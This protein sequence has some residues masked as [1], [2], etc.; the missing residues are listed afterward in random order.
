MDFTSF[1][2]P[3]FPLILGSMTAFAEVPV[4]LHTSPGQNVSPDRLNAILYAKQCPTLEQLKPS[5]VCDAFQDVYT[6]VDQVT[7]YLDQSVNNK[8]E[9]IVFGQESERRP[10]W[11]Y[12]ASME[13]KQLADE[14]AIIHALLPPAT[15]SKSA[16]KGSGKNEMTWYGTFFN[17]SFNDAA[18][19]A[20]ITSEWIQSSYFSKIDGMSAIA[21]VHQGLDEFAKS[22]NS[23]FNEKLAQT[24]KLNDWK[25]SLFKRWQTQC[26]DHD[27]SI[28]T[29]S[30]MKQEIE[31][32]N[33]VISIGYSGEVD[34]ADQR[35]RTRECLFNQK[36][37][38][39]TLQKATENSSPNCKTE[40][41][42]KQ[43]LFDSAF[44]ALVPLMKHLP[45]IW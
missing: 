33:R 8:D 2:N 3:I 23:P 10:S 15:N 4:S 24:K 25:G 21:F 13:D 11:E 5:T 32:S 18:N 7:S 39:T 40:A 36:T 37:V 28:W 19:L 27:A 29:V 35:Y 45:L 38:A 6:M 41:S 26:P 1:S 43:T 34:I 17:A 30:A 20:K 16:S 9:Y 14:Y 42:P 22:E 31:F 44:K 12:L